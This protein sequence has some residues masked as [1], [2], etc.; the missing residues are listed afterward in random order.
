MSDTLTLPRYLNINFDVLILMKKE[1]YKETSQET[2]G[3]LEKTLSR[4]I[5]LKK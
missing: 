4:Y 3:L 1:I 2:D 5:Y